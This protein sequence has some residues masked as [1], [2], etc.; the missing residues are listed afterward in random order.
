MPSG[1]GRLSHVRVAPGRRYFVTEEG[2]PFLVIGHNDA[3]PWPG[4][5]PLREERTEVAGEDYLRMLAE[6]GVT[7][8]RVMLEYGSDDWLFEDPAG[9]P[10]PEAVRY[11]DR[12]IR[13]CEHWGVRLLAVFWDT[14]HLYREWKRHPYG[15]PGGVLGRPE[16]FC[17]SPAAIEAQKRRIRFFVDRWG[18][19]PALFGYDLFNELF[20]GWGG[21]PLDQHRWVAELAAFTKACELERWGRRHLITVS[22]FGGIPTEEYR[23]IFFQHPELDF[24]SPHIYA[25]GSIDNP[26]NTID[27]ALTVRE[28]VRFGLAQM[29]EPRPYLDSENGPIHLFLDHGRCL[30]EA[31][32]DEYFHNMSW[33]HLASG[34]AGGGMRWPFRHPHCLTPGMH[35]AQRA[36]SRFVSA[37][38]WASFEAGAVALGLAVVPRGAVNSY[39]SR[40]LPVIPFG[41]ADR[42][43]A[44]VWLLRDLRVLAAEALLPPAELRLEGLAPGLYR[45][46]FWNTYVGVEMGEH[47]FSIPGGGEA[48]VPLPPLKRDLAIAIRARPGQA[49]ADGSGEADAGSPR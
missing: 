20:P 10:R 1:L 46:A 19:S 6:H 22:P 7:V 15:R 35:V 2:A 14:Y 5:V 44:L 28:A 36:M 11:W 45:A 30:P 41:C 42:R 43:Q 17:T 48:L 49:A 9:C 8:L 23:E 39:G 37:L 33:A 26:E 25:F 18:G 3:M 32:D 47:L 34:G 40:P 12:L 24:V 29:A 4:L 31:F 38:D 21:S 27:C 13:L 16:D